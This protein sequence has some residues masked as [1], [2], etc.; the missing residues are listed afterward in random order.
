MNKF[1]IYLFLKNAGRL[2]QISSSTPYSQGVRIGGEGSRMITEWNIP[3]KPMEMETKVN[4]V[5]PQIQFLFSCS[6]KPYPL[7]ISKHF[8]Q[9]IF[10]PSFLLVI[11]VR[12]T[13]F[14]GN[15]WKK[16]YQ[17]SHESQPLPP[18]KTVFKYSQVHPRIWKLPSPKEER[19]GWK[20]GWC[21]C[22][23]VHSSMLYY[24]QS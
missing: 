12:T 13:Q 17:N 20:W 10:L 2:V 7:L 24:H 18:T 21:L 6:K 9:E 16:H 5:H 1:R 19:R 14:S 23:I 4:W 3:E 22:L 15:Q 11:Q 8:Y